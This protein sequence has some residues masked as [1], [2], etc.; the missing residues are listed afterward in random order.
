MLFDG[1]QNYSDD[2]SHWSLKSI[3]QAACSVEPGTAEDVGTILKIVGTQRT[4]FAVKSGGHSVNPGFSSTLGVQI[5]LARFHHV[6]YNPDS[7]TAQIGPGQIWDDVYAALA[8]FNVTVVGGRTPGVGVG[9][10]LLGGGYSWKTNQHGLSVDNILSMTVVLPTGE[11]VNATA[12]EHPDL[13]FALKGVI[14]NYVLK[15]YPQD[16]VWGGFFTF[17]MDEI[18]NVI[19]AS[20]KYQIEVDDPKAQLLIIF[21]TSSGVSGLF[22]QVQIFYD[23]PSPPASI[24]EDFLQLPALTGA[25]T[26]QSFLEFFAAGY[27][28]EIFLPTI[29]SHAETIPGYPPSA[30]PATRDVVLMPGNINAIWS[31]P[32]A[33][34]LV[35][36]SMVSSG[37][38]LREKAVALGQ[39]QADPTDPNASKYPNYAA[40]GTPVEHL[41]GQHLPFLRQI[42]RKYDPA[43]VMCLAGGFK[44]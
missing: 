13:F 26:T 36:D 12:R 28:A 24:F 2:I 14:V 32:S 9:G 33:D 11:I 34:K 31:N 43:D 21:G 15:T 40:Y 4:P 20:S 6:V 18:E 44:I 35:H 42:K 23:A 39:T 19:A 8:P 27:L 37:I 5:S 7:Q 38:R 16:D 1:S 25:A 22:A 17:G 41:Y 29:Y 3:E 30:Y 10:L